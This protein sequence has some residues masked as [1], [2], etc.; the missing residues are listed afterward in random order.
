[1]RGVK[2]KGVVLEGEEG[3]RVEGVLVMRGRGEKEGDEMGS[4]RIWRKMRRLR[5]EKGKRSRKRK[6]GRMRE[7]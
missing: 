4:R 1:M 7:E 3:K 5:R 6:T 2:G